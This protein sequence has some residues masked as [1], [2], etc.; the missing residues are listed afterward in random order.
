[1]LL[2]SLVLLSLQLVL[3]YILVGGLLVLV[4]LLLRLALL[5]IPSVLLPSLVL[6]SLQPE[7]LYILEAVLPVQVL[8]YHLP[9]YLATLVEPQSHL[10]QSQ[11][12]PVALVGLLVRLFQLQLLR[13]TLAEL[14]VHP[15]L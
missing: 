7:L 13:V 3:L 5:C 10:C 12:L 11:P 8:L 2:P 6:L 15:C 9:Q 1:M 14:L 4:L